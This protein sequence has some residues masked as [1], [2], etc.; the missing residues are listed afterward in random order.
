M[1]IDVVIAD[2]HTIF[3]EGLRII[4]QQS[5]H[6][7]LRF[8]GEA[9]TGSDLVELVKNTNPDIAITDI[10]MP[11]MNGVEATGIISKLYPKTKCIGLSLYDEEKL[12]S[13]MLQ[14]GAMGYL[15]KDTSREELITAIR[16]VYEGNHYL[17][18]KILNNFSD[19]ILRGK[20]IHYG[21]TKLT[22]REIQVIKLIC[23]EY[24][25]REIATNLN[26][27]IRTIESYREHI[28]KKLDVKNTAGIVMYAVRNEL[29]K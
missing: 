16:N 15:L 14:A 25:N 21:K 9:G 23:Q 13:E 6:Y 1:A 8:N 27:Q 18:T 28:L 20:R 24:S 12:V 5:A 2:D 3:R 7:G 22:E 26:L 11:N 29:V 10:R 4:I 19:K 17:H